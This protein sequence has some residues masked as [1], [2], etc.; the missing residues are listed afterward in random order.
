MQLSHFITVTGKLHSGIQTESL[1]D[2]E[3]IKQVSL[4]EKQSIQIKKKKNRAAVR[5]R[6]SETGKLSGEQRPLRR[7]VAQVL[8]KAT[9]QTAVCKK[10]RKPQISTA[11]RRTH[12]EVHIH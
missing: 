6:S 5:Q 9:C 3:T 4:V 11:R 10:K 2:R 1:A 8:N 7:C 12:T